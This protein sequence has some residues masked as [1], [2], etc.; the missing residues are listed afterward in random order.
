MRFLLRPGVLLATAAVSLLLA[1]TSV[2]LIAWMAV[3]PERWFPDAFAQQGVQ[4]PPGPRGPVGPA[5]PPGPVGP[6]AEEAVASLQSDVDDLSSSLESLSGHS[7]YTQL[8]SDLEDVEASVQEVADKVESICTEFSYYDG[9]FSD[10]YLA[11]C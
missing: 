5:G 10:I 4:G 7:G 8:E 6:D 9:A 11:A 3:D 1:I 2:G